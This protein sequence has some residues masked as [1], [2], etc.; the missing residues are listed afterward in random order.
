M[1]S[2]F[3]FLTKMKIVFVLLI[4]LCVSA[5]TQELNGGVSYEVP[6]VH[7][8]LGKDENIERKTARGETTGDCGDLS[9]V[10]NNETGTLTISGQ[11]DMS[12]CDSS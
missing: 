12:C 10:F 5:I 1:N 11:G 9:W 4:A 3:F 8:G 7:N 2:F 6:Q